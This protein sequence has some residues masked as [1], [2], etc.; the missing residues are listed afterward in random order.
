[1]PI[2]MAIFGQFPPQ[3]KKRTL[4]FSYCLL[5]R[6]FYG[7][8]GSGLMP[9]AAM[10]ESANPSPLSAAECR[11]HAE[12]CRKMAKQVNTPE[13]RVMLLHMA[14]TWDRLAGGVSNGH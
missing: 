8:R 13:H 3:K 4:N 11:K 1:M 6:F 12:Q 7:R 10:A 14:E 5:C 9:G 2:K